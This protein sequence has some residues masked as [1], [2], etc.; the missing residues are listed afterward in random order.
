HRLGLVHRD[1]KPGNIFA[2]QRGGIYDTVKLLDFGLV[3]PSADDDQP[4]QLTTDGAI[5][6]SPLFMSPE[7]AVGDREPDAR[8]DLYSLGAVGYYL[9]TGHPPFEGDKPIKVMIAHARDEVVPPSARGVD[10]PADL[11]AVILRCLGKKTEDRFPNAQA[12][13]DALDRC[14]DEGRWTR[15]DAKAWWTEVQG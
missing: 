6:G 1:I 5:T 2:A 4:V 15:A 3:K 9:L 11:E 8:S 10:V 7:Q 13:A 14:A 12:M